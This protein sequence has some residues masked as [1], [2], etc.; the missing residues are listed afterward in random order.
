MSG[1]QNA[2]AAVWY[3]HSDGFQQREVP[4][5]VP[6]SREAVVRVRAATICG[7]DLHSLRGDREVPTPTI[8]GHE[9]VGEIVAAGANATAHDGRSLTLGTRVTWTIGTAC[10]TCP[11]CSR[12]MGQKCVGVR[13]YGHEAV[14]P[15]WFLNGGLATH[16][17]LLPDTGVV[18][19]PAEI[20]DLVAAPANC[21]TSTVANALA[22]VR[23]GVVRAAVVQGCGML[24]L[25]AVAWLHERGVET[26]VACDTDEDRRAH[27]GSFG[28]TAAVSP[29]EL[30][31]TVADHTGGEGADLVIE[32]S[33]SSAAVADSVALLAIG[34]TLRLVGSVSPSAPVALHAEDIVR[35]LLTVRGTHNYTT[36]DLVQAV[37]F[38]ERS[39]ATYPFASLVGP[40]FPLTEI[41]R[42]IGHAE[43]HRPP[44]VAVLPG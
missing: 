44:R 34:G 38:L 3:G 41:D 16:C 37:A 13:K 35:R 20:P 25:T 26:I 8:L 32:L 4:I 14:S 12:G 18:V 19:V 29:D 1:R 27:A 33:G 28:A 36:H 40:R 23:K 15:R 22:D 21:A 11:R 24:G 43:T 10:G 39:H 9:A 6:E 7:S 30:F 2:H 17:H 42:A 5:P 31:T